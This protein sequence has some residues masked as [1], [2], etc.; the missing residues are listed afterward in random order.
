M[1]FVT[2]LS[3]LAL[4]PFVRS[5]KNTNCTTETLCSC[6]AKGIGL[7][8]L[9]NKE[10]N[11][12]ESFVEIVS[13]S[14]GNTYRF[15]PCGVDMAWGGDCDTTATSCQYSA[16]EGVYY[17]LGQVT[18][19]TITEVTTQNKIPYIT[20]FYQGGS[21]GRSSTITIFCSENAKDDSLTFVDE[22][23]QLDYNL[24]FVTAKICPGGGVPQGEPAVP[25][26][27]IIVILV[28]FLATVTYLVVGILL[29]VLWK[30]ARGL[31]VIPNLGFW[32][33]FPFL[34]KDGV[35]FSF[36]YIPAARS[37][38]GGDKSYAPLK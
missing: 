18:D 33:D 23:P 6:N 17:S 36:S 8:S 10:F 13:S 3:L 31:E 37:H 19:Y 2:F 7:M 32:K 20:F 27:F 34:F 22:F 5:Q 29:M 21:A 1:K 26:L 25:A 14:D 38:I 28:L 35:L 16:Q 4:L 30:G 24:E 15:Y 12:K 9:V 11:N